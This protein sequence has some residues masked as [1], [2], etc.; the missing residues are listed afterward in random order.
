M[1]LSVPDTLMIGAAFCV[2]GTQAAQII[3]G[4]W[5]RAD[6]GSLSNRVQDLERSL[7]NGLSSRMTAIE[8]TCKER[9][10]Q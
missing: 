6:L 4:Q 9:H 5:I 3:M 10:P 8:S 2:A 1:M 7:H